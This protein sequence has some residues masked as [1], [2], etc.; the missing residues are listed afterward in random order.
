M[1]LRHLLRMAH[2]VHNPP[3]KRRVVLVFG[4]VALCL[5]LFAIERMFGWPDALTPNMVRGRILP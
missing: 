1:N 5:A 4:I 2:W 3:S